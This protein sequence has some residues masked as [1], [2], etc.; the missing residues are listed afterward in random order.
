[1]HLIYRYLYISLLV[2][3]LSFILVQC[4]LFQSNQTNKQQSSSGSDTVYVEVDQRPEFPGGKSA[5]FEY[6]G[7]EIDYPEKSRQREVEGEVVI[8]FVVKKDGSVGKVEVQKS[9]SKLLD[10]EAKRVVREMP[11]WKPGR[12]DGNIVRVRYRVPIRFSL[13]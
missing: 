6:L 1:M 2:I 4:Q 3:G 11:Q 7:A 13:N 12:H 9:V 10:K 5:L 8:N